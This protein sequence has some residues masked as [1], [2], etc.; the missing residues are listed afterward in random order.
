MT[1]LHWTAYNGDAQTCR[2]L[3][4]NGANV[5]TYS[6]NEQ[7]PID[8]AGYT[9]QYNVIDTFLEIYCAQNGVKLVPTQTNFDSKRI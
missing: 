8:V 7:L 1:P 5:F 6:F 2:H 4:Q 3:I 9:P